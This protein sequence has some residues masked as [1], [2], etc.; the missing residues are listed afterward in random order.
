MQRSEPSLGDVGIAFAHLGSVNVE[1]HWD[2]GVP[3]WL[4]TER[5]EQCDM[6]RRVREMIFAANDV[7][8]LHFD[9]VHDVDK[10]EHRVAVTADN[11]KI[12]IEH[13]SLV[14]RSDDVADDE[15]GNLHRLACHFET[16]G[17]FT[18]VGHF[19]VH[20]LPDAAFVDVA[21]L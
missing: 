17:A 1:N 13:F 11:D 6:L 8:D 5:A 16:D 12:G 4:D 14:E 3:G 20:Q 18:F 15:I 7:G 10:M 9:V 2:V 21:A 19:F